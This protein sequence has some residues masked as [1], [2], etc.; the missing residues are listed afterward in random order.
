MLR[1]FALDRAVFGR[2]PAKKCILYYFVLITVITGGQ[3]IL[4]SYYFDRRTTTTSSRSREETP[5]HETYKFFEE[6]IIIRQPVRGPRTWAS[7]LLPWFCFALPFI[8]GAILAQRFRSGPTGRSRLA[9]I[10]PRWE[11]KDEIFGVVFYRWD[12]KRPLSKWKKKPVRT[13]LITVPIET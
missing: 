12:T 4:Y 8:S 13:L 7:S 11:G 1:A 6:F 9:I 10:S 3:K 2:L 5:K